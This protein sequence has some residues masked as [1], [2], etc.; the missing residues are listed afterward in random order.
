MPNTVRHQQ[1]QPT[2]TVLSPPRHPL[3][4]TALQLAR[5]WCA[6]HI[7]DGAPALA[8]AVKVAVA[9]GMHLPDAEPQLVAAVLLHDSPFLAPADVDLDTTLTTQLD[10]EVTRIVRTLQREHDAMDCDPSDFA[11][12]GDGS[13]V[14]ASAADKIVSITSILERAAAAPDQ[15]AFWAVRQPF[16]RAALYFRAFHTAATPQLPGTMATHLGRLVDG[17]CRASKRWLQ[18]DLTDRARGHAR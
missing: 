12:P 14:V 2:M 10:A 3:I 17:A 16:L 8:H 7:I 13:I 6:G 9:V 18:V 5:D 1:E 11:L 15:E 4:D